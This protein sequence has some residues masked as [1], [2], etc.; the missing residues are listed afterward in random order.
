MI[1][2]YHGDCLKLMPNIPDKSIDLVLAD[3]PY[4]TTHNSWD[5]IIP[6]QPL[7]AQYKRIIKDHGAILLFGQ[8]PFSSHLRLSAPKSI[9]FRY[10]WIWQ[11]AEAQGFLNVRKMPMKAYEVVSVFYKHLPTYNPQR[12]YG[13]KK[14]LR[15]CKGYNRNY[16]S[17]SKAPRQSKDGGRWPINIIKFSNS[18][19]TS[20]GCIATLHKSRSS[21]WSTS[22]R[23][24]PTL[25]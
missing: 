12:R 3:L 1:K 23:H 14:Y 21:Y 11:K 17:V 6:M 5:S 20:G 8:E 25:A 4:G 22:S 13:F 10:D 24:T 2:L 19:H 18:D 16:G 9:H 7:W 15:K